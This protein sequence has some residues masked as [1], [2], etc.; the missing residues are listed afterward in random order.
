MEKRDEKI[1]KGKISLFFIS[2]IAIDA[3]KKRD[4]EKEKKPLPIGLNFESQ[5]LAFN[6]QVRKATI[7]EMLNCKS[8]AKISTILKCLDSF[9]ISF[10]EFAKEFEAIS[11]QHAIIH[12]EKQRK[13]SS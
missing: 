8:L 13:T 10:L 7:S 12:Y 1:L 4:Y 9:G 3:S 2:K 11:E 6:S 5:E